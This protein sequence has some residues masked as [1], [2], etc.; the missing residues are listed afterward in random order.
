MARAEDFTDEETA[1]LEE[2]REAGLLEADIEE[3]LENTYEDENYV[4][5]EPFDGLIKYDYDDFIDQDLIP[6]E[7]SDRGGPRK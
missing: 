2:L 6:D 1:A 3:L 4:D 7:A 5:K